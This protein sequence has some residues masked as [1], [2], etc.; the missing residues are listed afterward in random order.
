MGDGVDPITG[1]P[2]SS[3]AHAQQGYAPRETGTRW[4]DHPLTRTSTIEVAAALYALRRARGHVEGGTVLPT[5]TD[6]CALLAAYLRDQG[7]DAGE[8]F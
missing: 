6:A 8:G 4:P 2:L 1:R 7:Y 3:M 5:F